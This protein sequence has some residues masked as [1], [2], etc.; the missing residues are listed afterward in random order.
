MRVAGRRRFAQAR[1]CTRAWRPAGSSNAG[2]CRRQNVVAVDD[3]MMR[4]DRPAHIV[5]LRADIIDAVLRR[6]VLHHDTQAGDALAQRVEHALDEHGL[7]VE[8]VDLRIGDLAM[9]AKRQADF[10]HALE[11]RRHLVEIAHA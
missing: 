2:G 9:N 8:N 6:D 5:A 10:G 1:R 3:E 4:R 7:A 11:H